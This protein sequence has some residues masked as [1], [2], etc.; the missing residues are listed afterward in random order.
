MTTV[1]LMHG[2]IGFG[3]TTISLEDAERIVEVRKQ[4]L[5]DIQDQ[6]ALNRSAYKDRKIDSGSGK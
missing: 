4:K 3:K 2:Y 6:D 5:K 1:L